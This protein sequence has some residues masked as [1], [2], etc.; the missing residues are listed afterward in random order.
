MRGRSTRS[1]GSMNQF[2]LSTAVLVWLVALASGAITLGLASP[3]YSIVLGCVG[4][5][6]IF[7]A[8]FKAL[9]RTGRWRW[10]DGLSLRFTPWKASLAHRVWL[11][12]WQ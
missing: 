7:V 11:C 12:L 4:L 8:L 9:A 1:L 2:R 5:F 10:R 6:A 3:Q